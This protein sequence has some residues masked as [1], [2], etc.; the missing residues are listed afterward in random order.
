MST[1]K[2]NPPMPRPV[3]R[4]VVASHAAW[5]V[6]GIDPPLIIAASVL[7]ERHTISFWDALI[8]E[9]ARRGGATLLMSEDLQTGR[10]FG[11]LTVVNPFVG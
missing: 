8:L 7:E 5:P 4:Q 9:A 1:R 3:A 2:L 11:D 10:T 6:V